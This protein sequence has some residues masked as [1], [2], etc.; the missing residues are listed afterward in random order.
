MNNPLISVIIPIYNVEKYLRD[1]V[2]SVLAQTYKNLEVILVDDGSSDGSARLC[3]DYALYDSRVTVIHKPNGGAGD[4]RNYGLEAMKGDYLAFVDSDDYWLNSDFIAEI[5]E[6]NIVGKSPDCVFFRDLSVY[7]DGS[8]RVSSKQLNRE[9]VEKYNRPQMIKYLNSIGTLWVSPWCKLLRADI[10]K[11]NNIR[12]MTGVTAEDIDF[13]FEVYQKLNTFS[14]FDKLSYAYRKRD[15]SVTHSIGTKSFDSIFRIIGKWS[16][17]I[18]GLEITDKEKQIFMSY[19]AYQY[20]IFCGFLPKLTESRKEYKKKLR[21][22]DYLLKYDMNP[23]VRKVKKCRRLV[24]FNLTCLI[25]HKYM[26]LR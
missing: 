24:G 20:C 1:C 19:L 8:T 14:Y 16:K 21:E 9:T 6:Q 26:Q 22:F 3:D 10:I 23:K 25:L 15:N 7:A 13:I 11:K 2:D 4:A 17:K 18:D 12:F 5:V